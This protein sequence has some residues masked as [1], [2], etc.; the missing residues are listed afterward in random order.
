[1]KDGIDDRNNSVIRRITS[2]SMRLLLT[3]CGISLMFIMSCDVRSGTAKR[4]MEKFASTPMPAFS[5]IPTPTPVDAE[6][7]I[8]VDTTLEGE[9]ISIT[10]HKETQTVAC[11]KY[12]RVMVNGDAGS[13]T[14]KGVCRRIMINGDG[15]EIKV[16]AATEFVINGTDNLVRYSRFVNGKQPLVIENQEGNAIEKASTEPV[17]SGSSKSKIAK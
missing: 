5:P 11:T 12:N 7:I 16:D 14:I 2:S 9:T 6:D 17:T 3:I 8:Q 4:E 1:M 13:I 10:G 15:N